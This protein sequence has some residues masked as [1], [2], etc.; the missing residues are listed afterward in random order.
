[1]MCF[2]AFLT[3]EIFAGFAG[4]KNRSRMKLRGLY[5]MQSKSIGTLVP[6]YKTSSIYE[7]SIKR[8]NFHDLNCIW[9]VQQKR[10]ALLD[11]Q[12]LPQFVFMHGQLHIHIMVCK[13]TVGSIHYNTGNSNCMWKYER[14]FGAIFYAHVAHCS[15]TQS[16]YIP[17]MRSA[18]L[19]DHI[20][21]VPP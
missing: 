3:F 11:V 4:K 8:G 17:S 6:V 13:K 15:L 19:H 12:R 14:D 21:E 20:A 18:C 10:S 1:M 7:T 16:T 2:D 9:K 5:G